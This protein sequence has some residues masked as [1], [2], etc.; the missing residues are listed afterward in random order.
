MVWTAYALLLAYG[1][2]DFPIFGF[3]RYLCDRD[4]L[5]LISAEGH[6]V[7][8]PQALL[9]ILDFCPPLQRI[10][11]Y[12]QSFG[13]QSYKNDLPALFSCF[14]FYVITIHRIPHDPPVLTRMNFRSGWCQ[15]LLGSVIVFLGKRDG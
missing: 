15:R 11:P 6:P 14:P 3:C 12:H 10:N 8:K 1:L 4:D 7:L 13:T 2:V 9:S 5:F